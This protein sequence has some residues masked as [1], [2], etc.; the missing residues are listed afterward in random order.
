MAKYDG[1]DMKRISPKLKD[2]EKKHI[3]V[4]Y[5]EC[6]FYTNDGKRGI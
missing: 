3:L 5:D 4:T 1:D 2:S 6:I